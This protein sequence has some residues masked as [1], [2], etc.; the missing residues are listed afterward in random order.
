MHREFLKILKK[1]SGEY[2]GLYFKSNTLLQ[3]D[4]FKTLI[5]FI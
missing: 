2:H 1:N 3:A 4:T 5:N